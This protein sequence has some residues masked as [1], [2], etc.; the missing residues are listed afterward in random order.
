MSV[1]SDSEK[2]LPTVFFRTPPPPP[3]P[4]RRPG[5]EALAASAASAFFCESSVASSLSFSNL[6][7]GKRRGFSLPVRGGGW[8]RGQR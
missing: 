7:E 4:P 2:V 8:E 1:A 6:R 3:P 5:L